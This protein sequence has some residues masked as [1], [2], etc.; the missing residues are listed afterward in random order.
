MNGTYY[1][2]SNSNIDT[3]GYIYNGSVDATYPNQNLLDYS[4]DG[5]TNHQFMIII[6]LKSMTKYI[7]VVTTSYIEVTGPFSIIGSGPGLLGFTPVNMTGKKSSSYSIT[8]Q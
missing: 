2:R 8:F 3:Y 6:T 5:G 7:L 4:D 1:I